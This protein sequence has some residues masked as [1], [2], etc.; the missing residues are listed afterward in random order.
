M[1]WEKNLLPRNTFMPNTLEVYDSTLEFDTPFWASCD[2]Q[3]EYS[4]VY[5]IVVFIGAFNFMNLF[6]FLFNLMMW[7]A[8]FSKYFFF[9]KKTLVIFVF[10]RHGYTMH[11][12]ASIFSIS[13][14][15]IHFILVEKESF[16]KIDLNFILNLSL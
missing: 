11:W 9:F 16:F 8:L 5:T 14:K 4:V 10:H 15:R 2:T 7:M 3:H 12:N 1:N 6:W 13:L